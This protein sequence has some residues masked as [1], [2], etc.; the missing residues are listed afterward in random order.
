V[1][2]N[3][4]LTPPTFTVFTVTLPSAGPQ[5]VRGNPVAAITSTGT[6]FCCTST[7]PFTGQLFIVLVTVIRYVPGP[8]R[9]LTGP[10]NASEL[11][12]AA[13]GVFNASV[14]VIPTGL[15]VQTKL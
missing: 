7:D 12:T 1:G 15:P 6:V 10:P 8:M 2:C 3:A 11:N 9:S 4:W 5:L 13:L 14:M